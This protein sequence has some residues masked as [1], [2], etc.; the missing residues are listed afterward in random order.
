LAIEP[1]H[2]GCAAEWTFLTELDESLEIM[3]SVASPS[4]RLVFDAYHLGQDRDMLRRLPDLVPLLALVQLGDARQAPRGEQ[5]RCRLGEGTIPLKEMISAF[6]EA[7]YDGFYDV[8]LMGE[9]LENSN[10][11][12]LILHSKQ[13]FERLSGIGG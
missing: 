9:D 12:D 10:Y 2:V 3:H 1:M 6:N 7:G 5:N 8:E 13:V 11:R 4:V